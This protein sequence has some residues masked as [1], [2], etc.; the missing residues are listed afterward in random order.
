MEALR[1]Q[2]AEAETLRGQLSEMESLR[3]R[4][5]EADAFE[6]Q[7]GELEALRA[8]AGEVAPLQ[9]RVAELEEALRPKVDPALEAA[10]A[11]MNARLAETAQGNQV[12]TMVDTTGMRVILPS[13]LTHRPAS[14]LL[15]DAAKPILLAIADVASRLLPNHEI[16]IEGH[17][18]DQPLFDLPYADN[19]GL[20][21]ARADSV[22]KFL[23]TEGK[24]DPARLH[25]VARSMFDPMA[26]NSA[27]E[28][29]ARNR[30]VEIV[31]T[32]F[33]G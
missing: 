10:G 31:F 3:A 4:A 26:D 1:E 27:A 17:T 14:V 18:D 5:A 9:A 24:L 13:D 16:R 2:A 23:E 12:L 6:A 29:R 28:G 7:L 22:R 19:W 20:S 25:V 8:Q 15:A 33:A 11:E 30:R 32:P 21:H